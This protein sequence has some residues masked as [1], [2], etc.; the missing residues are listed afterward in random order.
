MCI[1]LPKEQLFIQ[2]F[3]FIFVFLLLPNTRIRQI[4]LDIFCSFFV[5]SFVRVWHF[6]CIFHC[7]QYLSNSIVVVVFL[8]FLFFFWFCLEG[9]E[10]INLLLLIDRAFAFQA[11]A[12]FSNTTERH[13]YIHMYI[14]QV[15]DF[16]QNSSALHMFGALN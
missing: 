1:A 5:Y 13:T 3:L 16:V 6:F 7:V 9:L 12:L 11:F 2:V 15:F 4:L 10:I 8:A 14:H